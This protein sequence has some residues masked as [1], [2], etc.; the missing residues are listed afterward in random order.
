MARFELAPEADADLEGIFDYT[1]RLWGVE[2]A[3]KY[4]NQ[5]HKCAE[6]I[7]VG[8]GRY[9]DLSHIRAGLRSIRCQQHYIYF[10]RLE[11]MSA[12]IVAVLHER[13]DLMARIAERL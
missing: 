3:Y 5:L 1:A 9:K 7:A 10:V 6:K 11:N 8:R 12:R 13:M 4:L 2:Q